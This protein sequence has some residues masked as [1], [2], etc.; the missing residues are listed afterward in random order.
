[1]RY[2]ANADGTFTRLAL[3]DLDARRL[4]GFAEPARFHF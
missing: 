2:T 4:I 3:F 1:V